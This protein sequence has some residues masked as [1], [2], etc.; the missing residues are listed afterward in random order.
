MGNKTRRDPKPPGVQTKQLLILWHLNRLPIGKPTTLPKISCSLPFF[1][2]DRC[3]NYD[4]V[5]LCYMFEILANE[6]GKE[7]FH[8]FTAGLSLIS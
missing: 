1:N 5:R 3:I 8:P 4:Y 2:E 7:V 6:S